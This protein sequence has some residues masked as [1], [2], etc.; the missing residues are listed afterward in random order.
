MA[1]RSVARAM[2]QTRAA[3]APRRTLSSI[4]EADGR[5]SLATKYY[6]YTSM[7][8]IPLTP[9]AFLL[10]PSPM[11]MPVDLALGIVIPIHAHI[12]MNYVMTD[13]VK[14]FI[15]KGAVGPARYIML[16]ATGVTMAGL[17]KLNLT[18]PGVTESVKSM[19]RKPQA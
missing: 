12:G 7:A 8:L 11:C 17:L 16:G 2:S 13:Y 19:W 4:V 1:L 3:A 10:S 6:H 9:A 15:G 5:G 18:G 14:K